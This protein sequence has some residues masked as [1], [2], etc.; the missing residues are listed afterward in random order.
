M[1][2]QCAWPGSGNLAGH[3]AQSIH[4]ADISELLS[5]VPRPYCNVRLGP[6][7]SHSRPWSQPVC[8]YIHLLLFFCLCD[9]FSCMIVIDAW[10]SSLVV[11]ALQFQASPAVLPSMAVMNWESRF[12]CQA[13]LFGVVAKG[14]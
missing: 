13:V 1:C 12:V 2:R 6:A 3:A 14:C 8:R 9:Y 5:C 7:L 4:V 10:L 11:R